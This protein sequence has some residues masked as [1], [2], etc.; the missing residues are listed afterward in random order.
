[1]AYTF[2]IIDGV[3]QSREAENIFSLPEVEVKDIYT[4]Q[5]RKRSRFVGRTTSTLGRF[6]P[7]GFVQQLR[8]VDKAILTPPPC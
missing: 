8:S 1:V 6:F 3:W 7:L 5:I 4:Q 2:T